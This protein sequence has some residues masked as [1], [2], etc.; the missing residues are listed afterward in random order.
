MAIVMVDQINVKIYMN[1]LTNVKQ[2]NINTSLSKPGN[3]AADS[4]NP[5]N[6]LFNHVTIW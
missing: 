2:I 4:E 3:I 5:G 6:E 1:C